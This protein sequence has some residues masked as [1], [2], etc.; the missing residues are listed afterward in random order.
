MVNEGVNTGL[1][2]GVAKVCITPPVGVW[3]GGFG[4][5]SRPCEGIHDDLH[6]RALVLGNPEPQ[7]AIVSLDVVGLTHEVADRARRLAEAATGIP[8]EKIALCTS[9]THGGPAIY[10]LV[11]YQPEPDPEYLGVLERYVA[12]A[13]TAA[14][15][16]LAPV[17]V[18]LGRSRAS[19]TVNRRRRNPDGSVEG[20]DPAGVADPEVLVVR[21]DR[22]NA[23]EDVSTTQ[24][25]SLTNSP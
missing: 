3:Q 15:R 7:A 5:R 16:E 23:G 2:A 18:R 10:G 11:G 24:Q 25:D 6:A 17:S 12:G 19:F 13:V 22:V 14:A 21:L 1:T 4:G 20:Y 9:H 8:A